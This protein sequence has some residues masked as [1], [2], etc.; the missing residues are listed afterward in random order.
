[1]SDEKHN[2]I[3]KHKIDPDQPDAHRFESKEEIFFQD[4]F[5]EALISICEHIDRLKDV[6]KSDL[7]NPEK[8]LPDNEERLLHRHSTI[9]IFGQR[10]VGK[11]SFLLTIKETFDGSNNSEDLDLNLD[12]SKNPEDLRHN[13]RTLESID[14]SLIENEDKLLVTIT[15]KILVLRQSSI[16]G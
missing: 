15:S 16:L 6:N 13:V 12:D 10:G 4:E 8:P 14:P 11:T 3:L 7:E 1:M 2:P 5:E 9:G